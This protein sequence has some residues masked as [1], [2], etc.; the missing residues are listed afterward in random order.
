MLLILSLIFIFYSLTFYPI[1]QIIFLLLI[2]LFSFL[3]SNITEFKIIRLI[4]FKIIF[5]I[6]I[7]NI[8]GLLDTLYIAQSI[9]IPLATDR[10]TFQDDFEE[11]TWI[12]KVDFFVIH[13][14]S[15]IEIIKF[16]E[17]LDPKESYIC[18]ID[19]IPELAYYH[20]SD[21]RMFISNPFLINKN[22]STSLLIDFIFNN[23][24]V[25]L[26]RSL[27][28]ITVLIINYSR[29]AKYK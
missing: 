27:N 17:T 1:Y 6:I 8:L 23:D 3:N 5:L 12:N 9:L 7:L 10:I 26:F 19:I 25:K 21:P 15:A 4:I 29:I 22:I 20:D 2:L 13:K 11:I 16:I 24:D 18:T 14:F 28:K